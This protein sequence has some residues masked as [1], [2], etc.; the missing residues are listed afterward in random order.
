[1]T[2]FIGTG[3]IQLASFKGAA[4][5]LSG[6]IAHTLVYN[7]SLTASEILENFNALKSRFGLQ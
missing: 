4:N 5:F 6:D 1:M 2:T 3:D 7:R